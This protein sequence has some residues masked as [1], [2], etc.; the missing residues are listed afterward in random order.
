MLAIF[1]KQ[2]K[3]NFAKKSHYIKGVYQNLQGLSTSQ[4]DMIFCSSQGIKI[5]Y[6]CFFLCK[7][8][9]NHTYIR[10]P[11]IWKIKLITWSNKF[12]EAIK[13]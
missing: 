4:R 12:E 1:F 10:R 13:Q 7:K 9:D 8:I 2:K 6:N 5:T 11:N 3:N